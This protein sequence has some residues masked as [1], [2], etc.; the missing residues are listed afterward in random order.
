MHNSTVVVGSLGTLGAVVADQTLLHLKA[1][2]NIVILPT[3][4]AFTGVSETATATGAV[5]AHLDAHVETLMVTDRASS[6][7]LNLVERIAK[8]DLV[9]LCDGSSLHARSVWRNSPVGEAIAAAP[10]LVVIGSVAAVL[11]AAMI[12]PRGG[13]PTTGLSLRPGIAFCSPSSDEQMA[14]TR[15]LV[16]SEITLVVLG[17]SGVLACESGHWR[18]VRDDD[19]VV[20]RGREVAAL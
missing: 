20:T 12:D 6:A 16:S 17:P 2:A 11:G 14:R 18:V 9:V 10:Q 7:D 5:F 13:A 1:G 4:A 19:V 15:S 3:A 8:A